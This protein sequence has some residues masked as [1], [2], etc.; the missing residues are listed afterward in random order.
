MNGIQMLFKHTP[1]KADVVSFGEMKIGDTFI[2][3][4]VQGKSIIGTITEIL[5]Q[6]KER[7]ELKDENNRRN[8]AQV[9]FTT[10]H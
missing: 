3:G 6:R 1:T 9:N 2:S 4:N 7:G 5:E 8:W 10:V